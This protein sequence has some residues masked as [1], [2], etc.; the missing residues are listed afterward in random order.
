[1]PRL[2]ALERLEDLLECLLRTLGRGA[3]S[4]D[5][6]DSDCPDL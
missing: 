1:M 3:P 6:K 2:D 4:H 5:A